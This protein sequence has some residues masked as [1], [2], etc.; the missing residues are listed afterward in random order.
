MPPVR[1]LCYP[2]INLVETWQRSTRHP[3]LSLP[4]AP[5][6]NG[7]VDKIRVAGNLA[8]VVGE[9]ANGVGGSIRLIPHCSAES[10][11]E[12]GDSVESNIQ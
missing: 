7:M 2:A 12:F 9:F 8:Y 6:S 4:W 11:H 1:S 5:V 10:C 3:A